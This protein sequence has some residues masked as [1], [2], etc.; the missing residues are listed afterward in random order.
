MSE[1]GG[2]AAEGRH[3]A[4]NYFTLFDLVGRREGPTRM[5]WGQLQNCVD[6]SRPLDP[7]VGPLLGRLDLDRA[8]VRSAHARVARDLDGLAAGDH[9]LELGL[10]AYPQRLAKTSDAPQF[11]FVRGDP[12]LLDVAAIAVVGT[13]E[14]SDGGLRRA[15]KL[16]H[17]LAERGVVVTSGLARGIDRA[18][19]VGALETGGLTIAVIGT[20]LTISY[21]KEHADLQNAIGKLGVV[22]S[23]F[24]PGIPVHRSFF[25]KRNATMSGLCLGTVVVEASET[26]GALIQARQCLAQGRKLFIPQSALD[27][28][29]LTW[30]K[31]FLE[32]GAHRFATI[33]E[34]LDVLAEE[35]LVASATRSIVARSGEL[36]RA[37]VVPLH[38]H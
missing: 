3:R 13:R 31:R 22:V 32:R 21:P 6:L 30:P 15:L 28:R 24:R 7:A 23:Q 20:P 1:H 18:A 14:A 35:G 38:V 9:I 17:L 25:P 10:P 33:E 12:S 19:H 8:T 37:E 5:A 16:S 27:D 34:L 4:C 36:P 11:L 29:R 2:S 26:S